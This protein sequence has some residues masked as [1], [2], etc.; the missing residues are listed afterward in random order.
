MQCDVASELKRALAVMDRLSTV[1]I[2]GIAA[3]VFEQIASAADLPHKAPTYAPPAPPVYNWTGFY[4]GANVGAE[5]MKDSATLN[6]PPGPPQAF[7]RFLASGAIPT[8]YDVNKSGVIGTFQVGYN[9]QIERWVLGLETDISGL[10]VGSTQNIFTNVPAFVP[11]ALTYQTNV[12][13]VGTVRA[14]AGFLVIPTLLAYGT[15]GFA[16]GSVKHLYSESFSFGAGSS[17]INQT[18]GTS[19]NIEIGWTAGGGLEWAITDHITVRGE[20][21]YVKFSGESFTTPS[22]NPN[23]SDVNACSFTLSDGVRIQIARFGVNYK[24]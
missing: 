10:R 3:V 12:D 13:Y 15:G 22:N 16:Y 21:L 18:T 24:F 4:I 1:L 17:F 6:L 8:A 5:W 9:W 14:R 20:Y 19:G 23:C 11:F 7:A 2:G